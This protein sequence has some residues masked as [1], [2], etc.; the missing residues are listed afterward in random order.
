MPT[1]HDAFMSYSHAADGPL[2]AALEGGLEQLAK[3]LL[4]RRALDV[5]RD[6]T[7]LTA[8]PALWPGIV[9]H[10]DASE[11]FLLLASPQSA[12]SAWCNREVQWWLDHRSPDRM[13]VLLT[14]GEIAWDRGAQDFDWS[15]TNAL[16]RFF[17][18]RCTDEPLH[19]DCRWARASELLTL[20]NAKFRDAV[21]SI[22]A[23]IRGV[24]KDELD[25][26][27]LR[28]LVRNRRLVRG[29]VAAITVAAV[30]A[31]WQAL[32]A[33]QQRTEAERQRDIAVSRQLAAQA[34]LMRVQ[35]P[36]RLPLAL[37]MAAQALRGQPESLEAQH[38]LR[39][40]LARIPEPVATFVHTAPV[41]VARLSGDLERLATAAQDDAGALWTVRDGVRVA[42]LPGAD[43]TVVWS[44]NDTLLAG[45][46]ARV[47]AW[48]RAGEPQL[49][50]TE[51]DLNG[52]A[53]DIAVSADGRYLAVGIS[54]KGWIGVSV[55]DITSRTTVL[56]RQ[57]R[58]E[59]RGV[60]IAF[61]PNGDFF[62]A[63]NGEVEWYPAGQWERPHMLNAPAGDVVRLAV[64][65]DG[66]HLAVASTSSVSLVSLR[67][68]EP[69]V[70]LRSSGFAPAD[71]EDVVFDA[72]GA[73][74]GAIPEMG[75]GAIWEVS[76]AREIGTP[77]HGE[78]YTIRSLAFSPTQ[79]E[80]LTCGTDGNCFT[81]SLADGGRLR[82]FSHVYAYQADARDARAL[83]GGGY[84]A[85]GPLVVTSGR[86]RTARLW[87]LSDA[88]QEPARRCDWSTPYIS[89]HVAMSTS[90][91][92]T[93]GPRDPATAACATRFPGLSR[94]V[95]DVDTAQRF[96]ATVAEKGEVHVWSLHDR[97]RIATL[98][99]EETASDAGHL[100]VLAIS[101]T[102]RR[103]A[104][105]R[106][107]DRSLRLWDTATSKPLLHETLAERDP[108]RIAFLDDDAVLR[109]DQGRTLSVVDPG[110]HATLWSTGVEGL[111][112]FTID[113][114]GTRVAALTRRDSGAL[115]RLWTSRS[116]HLLLEQAIGF[117]AGE[118]KLDRSGQYIVVV[119]DSPIVPEVPP[120]PAEVLVVD[121]AG[122]RAVL[123]VTA[124]DGT[125][126]LDLSRDGS[127]LAAVS[128]S[129]ELRVW[130]LPSATVQRTVLA[131]PGPV[132][133]SADGRWVAAGGG[134]IRV[135][136]A[137]TLRPAA[138]LEVSGSVLALEFQPDDAL[139]AVRHSTRPSGMTLDAYRWST[140]DLLG[141]ACRRIPMDAATR[142]W[143][144][145]LP[146]QP[147]PTPCPAARSQST[148]S[149]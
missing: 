101:S 64:S 62:A 17:E 63:V 2:A 28:Q 102:G 42:S 36:D 146:D 110:T 33:N 128:R 50:L 85:T 80:A 100:T 9:S 14:E 51:Q 11:W 10:L 43:R 18:R 104:T 143:T 79:P 141:E 115:L 41:N 71:I 95:T 142:Q 123:E 8:A 132:A 97:R 148:A 140:E 108:P 92:L 114:D 138:Q 69:P 88:A 106:T 149:R 70:L 59:T 94:G 1:R 96:G 133:F 3:P 126:A 74:V 39:D 137:S 5:F 20:R 118:V 124:T 134:S 112:A 13:L 131:T 135:L 35:Q 34:E 44:A 120:Q 22:A 47:T 52:R 16:P 93:N 89:T 107:S 78:F 113:A 117:N 98:A 27:D 99:H 84:G 55:H 75:A 90:W 130:E 61:A 129:G 66:R 56:R 77:S 23:P 54:G 127:R 58:D 82:Q 125:I 15:R 109:I 38:T 48:N 12:R 144:Q 145:L 25:G 4:K 57:G 122:K 24:A 73:R 21:V 19:V 65:P 83:G 46:C 7:S 103:V 87:N 119:G 68:S 45:C 60:P 121:I 40:L 72:T 32:V 105:F 30:I 86:D 53:E 49:Q 139:L 6:Q 37:L 26:A 76:T 111:V 91:H 29:G 31:V 116:G 67:Q 81:W 136:D 147:V